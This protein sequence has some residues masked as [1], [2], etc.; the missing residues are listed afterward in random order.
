MLTRL[1]S[2]WRACLSASAAARAGFAGTVFSVAGL[3]RARARRRRPRL[4]LAWQRVRA[5]ST[6]T[7]QDLSDPF[8]VLILHLSV[9]YWGRVIGAGHNF[10]TFFVL[11][12]VGKTALETL[13]ICF[14]HTGAALQEK[15]VDVGRQFAFFC[16]AGVFFPMGFFLTAIRFVSFPSHPAGYKK[17]FNASP[18]IPS[19]MYSARANPGTPKVCF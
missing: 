8:L 4:S 18:N 10:F 6:K 17:L 14:P 11:R 12:L 3:F 9:C 15:R 13:S 19:M 16:W 2:G 7:R 1:L 5:T